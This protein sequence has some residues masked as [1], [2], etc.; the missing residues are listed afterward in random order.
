VGCDTEDGYDY[1]YTINNSRTYS[2]TYGIVSGEDG[3]DSASEEEKARG[4]LR[5]SPL[6][7]YYSLVYPK[8]NTADLKD[9]TLIGTFSFA[10]QRD[11]YVLRYYFADEAANVTRVKEVSLIPG[12]IK[13]FAN[14]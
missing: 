2:A 11:A 9:Q 13:V 8:T 5:G 3:Y 6:P 14:E 10:S 12:A 1:R 4:L 7:M